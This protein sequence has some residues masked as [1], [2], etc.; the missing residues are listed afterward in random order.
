MV[1]GH[2]HVPEEG[3][4]GGWVRLPETGRAN[5]V[6]VAGGGRRLLAG[7]SEGK[8]TCSVDSETDYVIVFLLA[9]SNYTKMSV[10]HYICSLSQ[11]GVRGIG[12][13]LDFP[14][15]VWEASETSSG[16]GTS[17]TQKFYFSSPARKKNY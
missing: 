3:S 10:R 11:R 4:D 13:V 1:S 7:T 6:S 5:E 9:P 12:N 17:V 2:L 16:Q 8:P 14:I 15:L